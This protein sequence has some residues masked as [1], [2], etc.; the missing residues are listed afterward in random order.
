MGTLTQ[1]NSFEEK[2]RDLFVIGC[3]TDMRVSDLKRLS[4]NHI[5]LTN[6]ELYIE[7]E[8]KK[9]GKPVTFPV[10]EKLIFLLFKCHTKSRIF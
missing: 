5:K 8:M 10:T 1:Q 7:I 3:H 9:R 2:V 6:K 4:R